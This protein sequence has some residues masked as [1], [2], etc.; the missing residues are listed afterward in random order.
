MPWIAGKY[1]GATLPKIAAEFKVQG[2]PR[3]I[4]MKRD[5]SVINDDAVPIVTD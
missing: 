2:V 5:G 1:G 3:L 4:V